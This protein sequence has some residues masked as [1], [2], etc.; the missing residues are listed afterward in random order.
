[1]N[2]LILTIITVSVFAGCTPALHKAVKQGDAARVRELLNEGADV[3]VRETSS[4]RLQYTPLHWAAYLG[5]WEIGE[6]LLF[7]GAEIEA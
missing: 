6:M 4:D 7:S 3:N 5:D 2:R 1:M